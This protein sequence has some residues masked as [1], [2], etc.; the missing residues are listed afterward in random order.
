MWFILSMSL[1]DR[2]VMN[3][4]YTLYLMRTEI[5]MELIIWTVYDHPLDQ[6]NHW[7][8]RRWRIELGSKVPLNS[9]KFDSLVEARDWIPAGLVRMP[10]M[11]SDD[12]VIVE[13]WM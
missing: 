11:P 9:K 6:P 5:S 7:V 1:L 8:V 2:V 4:V 10:R 12:P 3:A 13:S